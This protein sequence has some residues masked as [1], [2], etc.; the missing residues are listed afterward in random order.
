MTAHRPLVLDTGKVRELPSGDVL[1]GNVLAQYLYGDGRD[2]DVTVS[3]SVTLT[4]DM[5]YNNLSLASG[6]NLNP[7]GWRIFVKNK[8]DLT[9]A[10]AG[11]IKRNGNAG[12]APGSLS[13][14]GTAGGAVTGNTVPGS[15]AG[16]AG[17]AGATM[18]GTAASVTNLTSVPI[19]GGKGGAAI[20][21]GA[22]G[23]SNVRYPYVR[24]YINA[25]VTNIRVQA[26]TGEV[27]WLGE[28]R[29]YDPSGVE[30]TSHTFSSSGEWSTTMGG[31][32]Y[33]GLTG[34]G[35]RDGTRSGFSSGHRCNPLQT[36]PSHITADFSGSTSVGWIEVAEATDDTA[37]SSAALNGGLVRTS[38]DSGSNYSTVDTYGA[39]Y[40]SSYGNNHYTYTAGASATAVTPITPSVPLIGMLTGEIAE[41]NGSAIQAGGPGGRGASG[42]G[43]K[44]NRGG[45]S[46]GGASGGGTVFI[47]ARQIDRG[48]STAV[49][50][51][52]AKGAAPGSGLAPSA[53]VGTDAALGGASGGSGSGGGL[54]VIV[55]DELLGS[56]A[57]NVIDVTGGDGANGTDGYDEGVGGDGG[58]SG[59]GGR[60]ELYDARNGTVTVTTPVSSVAGSAHSG[61]T[62]GAKGT[63]TTSRVSL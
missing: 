48:G 36:S 35:M 13:A 46:G 41:R 4:R 28:F 62:G 59:E 40:W 51:I 12:S 16:I 15:S 22:A 11:A 63:A 18:G 54:V 32:A 57:S 38:T 39:T 6:A 8:L 50:A 10:P 17:A 47:A 2:G 45:A 14:S 31:T 37:Q 43:D 53:G 5:F 24:T 56:T 52:Q 30:I 3:G 27:L 9:A 33:T 42:A 19:L 21:A 58:P 23:D 29:I 20:A 34:T 49:A 60:V 55:Y 1:L 26:K 25:S 61:I 7:G 44:A